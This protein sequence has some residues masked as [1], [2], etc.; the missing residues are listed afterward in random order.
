MSQEY[1]ALIDLLAIIVKDGIYTPFDKIIRSQDRDIVLSSLYEAL[2]Y[3]APDIKRCANYL[4]CLK[5]LREGESREKCVNALPI[6]G[7]D[8]CNDIANAID[9]RKLPESLEKLGE[10][11]E[12]VS[13]GKLTKAKRIAM[14]AV[15]R[16]L[17]YSL[18]KSPGQTTDQAT[19]IG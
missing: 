16:G 17:H 18:K 10:V 7:E 9:P 4:N 5:A 14:L 19:L 2:R 11:I 12:E 3:V 6:A 1:D 15:Q 13:R 8:R